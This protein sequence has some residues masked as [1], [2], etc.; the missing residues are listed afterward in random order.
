M[1]NYNLEGTVFS[2]AFFFIAI[3]LHDGPISNLSISVIKP[4][5]N[6]T[7]GFLQV[8][9]LLM[10]AA[11]FPELVQ[12]Y[13]WLRQWS[14]PVSHF[15]ALKCFSLPL[16]S[17]SCHAQICPH[18]IFLPSACPQTSSTQIPRKLSMF[19]F[20]FGLRM[21]E[22]FICHIPALLS[23]SSP[24]WLCPSPRG[25]HPA[26]V[27]PGAPAWVGPEISSRPCYTSGGGKP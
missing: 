5:K 3:Y 20:R 9:E 19:S 18:P 27:T 8:S 21:H 24:S 13:Q 12:K 15:G 26:A 1:V 16:F 14:G 6:V 17:T 2:T 7:V 22:T 4:K 25:E 11:G 10:L 23:Q